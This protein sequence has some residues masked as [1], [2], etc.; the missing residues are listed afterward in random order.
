M[1]ET[2]ETVTTLFSWAPKSVQMVTAAMKL[3]DT[4]SLE[5]KLWKTLKNTDITLL[6][7][8]HLVKAIIFPIVMHGYESWSIKK[9][10]FWRIDAFELWCCRDSWEFLGLQEI[11]PVHSKGN[12][13]WILIWRTDVEAEVSILWPPDAKSWLI[14]NDPDA[15]KDWGQEE[16]GMTE[17]EIAGW[18]HWLNGHEYE[19][20]PGDGEGLVCC[21]PWGRKMLD[22]TE[23]LQQQWNDICSKFTLTHC[24]FNNKLKT[25]QVTISR[26][27]VEFSQS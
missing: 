22:T 5:R 3:K 8:V 7:K 15:G 20:A 25:K 24:F 16:K 11:K 9:A 2:V 10:E 18:H 19:Q 4:C 27:I 6:T 12:Q 21:S 13:S 26:K 1:G 23:W 17:G 14:G